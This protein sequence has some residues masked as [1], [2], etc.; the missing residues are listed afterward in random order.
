M[1]L[2]VLKYF[3]TV[4]QE[5][6]F[7]RAAEKL[8]LSQPTLSRQL[9]DL[10]DEF[11]KQLLVREPRRI[12]LTEDGQ[13]LRRRAEEILSLVDKTTGEL[14][15]NA[16]ISGDIRIG[17]G[18]SIHFGQ[19][20]E[21]AQRLRQKHPG[22][23][24]HIVTGDGST[25]MTRLD[26][27]LIDFAFVY[28]KLD[29]AKYQELPLPVHDRWVLFLRAD[30]ELAQQDVIRA[31]DLWQRPLLFSRQTLSASTHG[32]ELLNWLQKPLAELNIAGSYTLLY[33]ATL[34]VKE[35][36]GYAISFDELINTTGT[37]LCT[38]PLEPAIFAEPSIAWKK[39][40]VFSKASQAF[41]AAL[42]ER[43]TL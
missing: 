35:G 40:A 2:R 7:S 27:G 4:A 22:L 29:P 19:I 15:R 24:F 3:L 14:L 5:E 37:N 17:A 28:G 32:D 11:G 36:M 38:R 43:F 6:S 18:E 12:L 26:R 23:R 30:D 13:L 10:E 41:L 39:N 8:H 25:T 20:M 34:M 1:E 33:N 16:E 42:Q 31:E 21:V 9:K